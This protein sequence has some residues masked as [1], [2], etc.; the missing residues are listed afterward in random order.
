MRFATVI[1]LGLAATSATAADGGG[2]KIVDPSDSA[3]P[4]A[5]SA[6]AAKPESPAADELT[7]K[8]SYLIGVQI[9]RQQILRITKQYDMD[10]ASFMR[11]LNDVLGGKDAEINEQDANEILQEFQSV[12]QGKE[13]AKSAGLKKE[14]EQW[15]AEHAKKPGVQTTASGLQYEVL[16]SGKG[17][18]KSPKMGDQVK[19]NYKGELRDGTVF[20]ASDKHGGPATFAVGQLIAGWNEAL[21]MMKEGDRWRLTVPADLA[22]GDQAPPSIG[23][24][25][26]LIFELE[27][28]EVLPP[29]A[30]GGA[31]GR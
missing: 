29:G 6:P 16:A 12:Q 19:C 28:L 4:A 3:A 15:L 21:Q 1:L 31:H 24:N 5:D 8:A 22:Y 7:K 13:A 2:L 9:G 11:G 27:L 26:I 30:K 25:Q 23:P 14:N 17:K 10:I 20:D 18:G